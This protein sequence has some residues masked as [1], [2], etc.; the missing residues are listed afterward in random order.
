M[1]RIATILTGIAAFFNTILG[2]SSGNSAAA[3]ISILT[4]LIVGI[5]ICFITSYLRHLSSH[6]DLIDKGTCKDY[7]GEINKK[8]CLIIKHF[9]I[10]ED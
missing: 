9:G 2:T 10:K 6:K 3:I 7:R 5:M 1:I 4:A 8:L